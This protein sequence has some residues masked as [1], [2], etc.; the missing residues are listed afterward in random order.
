MIRQIDEENRTQPL[1]VSLTADQIMAMSLR[2]VTVHLPQYHI[3]RLF[4]Q[5][6]YVQRN[7]EQGSCAISLY[8]GWQYSYVPIGSE[9]TRKSISGAELAQSLG[10]VVQV[11]TSESSL[12]RRVANVERRAGIA[13]AQELGKLLGSMADNGLHSAADFDNQISAYQR[14]E[15]KLR[16]KIAEHRSKSKTYAATAHNLQVC[17]TNKSVWLEYA[18]KPL[19]Q[20]DTFYKQNEAALP[21][22]SRAASQLDKMEVSQLVDPEKIQQLVSEAEN[23]I[24]ELVAELEKVQKADKTVQESK[25]MVKQIQSNE[26][27]NVML[28]RNP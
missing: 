9:K 15:M 23:R 22:Y 28:C 16:N 8:P 11:G 5:E 7:V 24:V 17:R 3:E 21:A 25:E 26:V 13:N 27:V 6:R 14:E 10:G 20:K 4:I 19:A 12:A 18:S 1:I 2:G